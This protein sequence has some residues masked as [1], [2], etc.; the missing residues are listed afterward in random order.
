MV[1]ARTSVDLHGTNPPRLCDLAVDHLHRKP[2]LPI[3]DLLTNEHRLPESERYVWHARPPQR[4]VRRHFRRSGDHVRRAHHGLGLGGVAHRRTCL[5][6]RDQDLLVLVGYVTLVLEGALMLHVGI[7]G[8]HIVVLH[9]RGDAAGPPP[10]HLVR[11]EFHGRCDTA[12][13]RRI[14]AVAAYAVS[15]QDVLYSAVIRRF[16]CGLVDPRLAHV[17]SGCI[18]R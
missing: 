6:P 11:R 4:P 16:R 15:G 17:L 14:R 1:H 10:G 13:G 2:W 3:L 9:G 18:A 7:P 5:S 8:W 12:E